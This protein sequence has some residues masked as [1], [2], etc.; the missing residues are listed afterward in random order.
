M[1]KS[2]KSDDYEKNVMVYTV[3]DTNIF[4]SA[5]HNSNL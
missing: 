2:E 5:L 1:K 3:I 4:V